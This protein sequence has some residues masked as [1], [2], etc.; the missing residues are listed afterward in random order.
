FFY[1]AIVLCDLQGQSTGSRKY[2]LAAAVLALVNLAILLTRGYKF[3]FAVVALVFWV[4]R[5]YLQSR[6][7]RRGKLWKLLIAVSVL[8]LVPYYQRFRGEQRTNL[9]IESIRTLDVNLGN[10]FSLIFRRYY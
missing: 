5:H 2:K 7:G 3:P 9:D 1:A 8:A 10:A 6:S 4:S